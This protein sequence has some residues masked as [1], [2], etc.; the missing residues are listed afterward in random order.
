MEYKILILTPLKDAEECLEHY[1]E[2][3]YQITYPLELVSLGFLESDSTDNTFSHMEKRLPEINGHFR[4][5]KLWKKDFRFHIPPEVPRWKASL[6]LERRIVLAKSRNHLLFHALD[7]QDWVLWM[8]VDL[9][10][11]PPDIIEKLLQTGKE[12]VQPN[13]VKQYGGKS[14]DLNAWR[15]KGRLHL[16]DLRSEGDLV[17]LHAV[18][19]SMLLV[20]A[21]IHRDGLVFPSLLYG[22][23]SPLIRRYNNLTKKRELFNR[24]DKRYMG[25]V[26]TEGLGIM[27]HDMGYKCWGMPNLEI[28]HRDA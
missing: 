10:E 25:E 14:F 4:S 17:P 19:A 6:Q 2:L 23:K 13:C 21:D 5:A 26:E 7:D 18:G 22:K 16:H 11:Y 27:A 9:I 1:F 24:R 8:D 12:I 20:K 15:D 28:R 3:L